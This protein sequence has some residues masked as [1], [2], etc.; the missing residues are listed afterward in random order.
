MFDSISWVGVAAAVAASFVLGFVWYGPLFSKP[1]LRELGKTEEDMR[2]D[3]G[4]LG[5]ILA[6]QL[7]ATVITATVLAII[8]ERFGTG[9]PT[10]L[11]IGVLC[12]AGLV[13]TAKL[14]DVLFAQTSSSK[15]YWI[16]AGY[17]IT[18]YAL[19]GAIYGTFA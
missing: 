10:G 6:V 8:I 11:T 4:E 12:A 14:S 9:I 1:W 13:A 19:M 15:R 7:V 16:E 3:G 5:P 18:S 17:Q 2:A